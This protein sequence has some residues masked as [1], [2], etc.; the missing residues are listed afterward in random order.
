MESSQ[1]FMLIGFVAAAYSV[2]ANDAIQTLGT[3]LSSNRHRHWAVLWL[4]SASILV[5]VLV[6]GWVVNHGDVAYG[7]LEKF[8]DPEGGI[9][10]IQA[11][12]PLFILL[13]TRFG[14]PVSTTF[15]VLTVFAPTN[16]GKMLIK[17]GLG[18]FV[19]AGV[20]FLTYAVVAKVFEGGRLRTGQSAEGAK[21]EHGEPAAYWVVLQWLSTGFLWTQWLVQDLANVFVYLPRNLG[22]ELL[23]ASMVMMLG[24]QALI[25]MRR[26]GAIQGIVTQKTNTQDIR[27]ATVVDFI[28]GAV[29][30]FFK[31]LSNLPMS[32]TWVFLGLLA[33]REIAITWRLR[34]QP[35]GTAWRMAGS[36]MA[37]AGI[38]LAVSLFLAFVLPRLGDF[39]G[40]DAPEPKS[41]PAV[42]RRVSE[43]ESPKLREARAAP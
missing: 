5:A 11:V 31:E 29:L 20:G 14:V 34:H 6:Y 36:D 10:W 7:R 39:F 22:I 4:Y 15:L 30:Y 9:G 21:S 27:S 26:G 43:L 17:S 13:L 25:F 1:L 18:Y 19:A 41:P 2:V 28:Y 33:G 40:S 16:T 24:M 42:E 35:F 32:T 38:G 12:P 23:M 3:F 37:K 8:P